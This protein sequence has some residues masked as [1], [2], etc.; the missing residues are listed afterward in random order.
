MSVSAAVNLVQSALHEAGRCSCC[1]FE[2]LMQPT[3]NINRLV[4]PL[5]LL[6]Q[7]IQNLPQF[8]KPHIAMHGGL[9]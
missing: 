5:R 6:P 2:Q 9:K 1:R 4:N 3:F 8:G 7:D